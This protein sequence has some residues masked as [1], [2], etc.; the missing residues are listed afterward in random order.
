MLVVKW[1]VLISSLLYFFGYKTEIFS[2]PNQSERSRSV[3]GDGSR[4]LGLFRKGK[5]S[6]KAKFHRTNLVI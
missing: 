4:S 3:L 6:I 1:L 2:L 5:I